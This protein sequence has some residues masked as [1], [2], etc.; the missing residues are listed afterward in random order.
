MTRKILLLLLAPA[1]LFACQS[2][3]DPGAELDSG[4]VRDTGITDQP[5]TDESIALSD[6]IIG[7]I[8]YSFSSMVEIPALIKD[9]GIPYSN[10]FLLSSDDI[11]H[12]SNNFER[13]FLLGVMG[14][15]L[16]YMNMYNRTKVLPVY[17]SALRQLTDSLLIGH[18]FDFEEIESLA[19]SEYDPAALIYN[20][21]QSYNRTD[22]YLRQERKTYLS[23][24]IVSGVW[25]EGLYLLT[26]A[27]ELQPGEDIFERIG[28]Q[29]I[30]LND[31]IIILRNHELFHPE[32]TPL[33]EK[34]ATLKEEFDNVEIIYEVDEPQAIERDGM[35][36]IVQNQRS[37]VNIAEEQIRNITLKTETIRDNLIF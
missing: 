33:I 24:V 35:L 15:D 3:R 21:M 10:R 25:V 28:E 17:L 1:L 9:L 7:E 11:T 8:I 20:Y 36:V 16:G 23:T 34:L 18:L 29:K 30:I 13:A 32:F 14:A 37:T 12:Y 5:F 19:G 26:R 31:L 22:E 2:G 4:A 27:A 6:E